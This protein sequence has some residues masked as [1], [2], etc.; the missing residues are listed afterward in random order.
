M[1]TADLHPKRFTFSLSLTQLRQLND[2]LVAMEQ[3]PHSG[4]ISADKQLERDR[5]GEQLAA[6]VAALLEEH[7]AAE[8][9]ARVSDSLPLLRASAKYLL[10]ACDRCR[11]AALRTALHAL[12]SGQPDAQAAATVQARGWDELMRQ[13]AEQHG[14]SSPLRELVEP[15][16]A[17]PDDLARI[18]LPREQLH[19]GE[20]LLARF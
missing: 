6:H 18:G 20:E 5:A 8:P 15:V 1:N 7:R 3:H 4:Q 14:V 11:R 9:G 16:G 12:D 10:T 17:T 13:L 19:G 2:E